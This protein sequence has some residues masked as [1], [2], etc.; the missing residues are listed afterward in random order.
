MWG[1]MWTL[2][3]HSIYP[4]EANGYWEAMGHVELPTPVIW[5]PAPFRANPVDDCSSRSCPN[6]LD[7]IRSFCGVLESVE[8]GLPV[9]GEVAESLP[10]GYCTCFEAY[11]MQC[12]LWFPLPEAVVQLFSRFGQAIGQVSPRGLHPVDARGKFGHSRLSPRNNMAII[13]GFVS[14]YHDWKKFF[15]FVRIDNASVEE[16]CIP[17]LTTR[18]GRKVTNP[19]PPTLDGL[20][21]VRDLLHSGVSYW[22]SFTPKRVRHAIA[23]HRSRF[24]PDL[25]VE[26]G[27]ESSMDGFVPC[28]APAERRRSRTRKDKHIVVDDDAGDGKCFPEDILGVYLNRGEPIDL[29]EVLGSDVPA[30]GSLPR[31][32]GWSTGPRCE[33]PGGS[34]GSIKGK[35]ADKQ[36]THLRDELECSRRREGELTSWEIRRAYRRRKREMAEVMN[37]R[38]TQF[39]SEFSEFKESYQALGDYRE[40]RGTVG[41]YCLTQIPDYSFATE[42]WEPIPVSPDT[43][44]A[45]M[46]APNEMGEVN[47]PSVPLNVDDYS[48][49]GSMTGY[50]EFDG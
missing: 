6:G 7:A 8:F 32:R 24:Q 43:V 40:C 12:H 18:W 20:C 35:S 44:E 49:G 47:Q 9:A 41:G 45:E 13:A 46:G 36:M 23:L 42:D 29:D 19:F 21:T 30:G 50:Y 37:K 31:H 15:F 1:K 28:E 26:E 3:E 39:L 5:H 4:K 17:I 22:A 27:K 34:H 38:L 10:D 48:M 11:L 2:Q 16:S 14:N 25:L 33:Q